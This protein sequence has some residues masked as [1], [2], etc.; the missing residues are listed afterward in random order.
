MN[1]LQNQTPEDFSSN[2]YFS[3][4]PAPPSGEKDV[5]ALRA[6]LLNEDDASLFDRYRAMFALRNHGSKESVEALAE[7]KRTGIWCVSYFP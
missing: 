6:S 3:V 5:T 4:D 7:G 2:P 1:W